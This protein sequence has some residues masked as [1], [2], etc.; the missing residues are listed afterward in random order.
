MTK[1]SF[2]RQKGS[3][4]TTLEVSL[5]E[6]MEYY[7]D[8][9][10]KSSGELEKLQRVEVDAHEL[11]ELVAREDESIPLEPNVRKEVVETF[12]RDDYMG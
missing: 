5:E 7:V 1:M 8:I 9:T 6:E 4:P 10:L 2:E 12:A 3:L 11:K